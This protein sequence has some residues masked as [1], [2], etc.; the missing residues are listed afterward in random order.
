MP[1][2][3]M[4][5][6]LQNQGYAVGYLSAL[7]VKENK[8][9]RKIDIK[10]VQRHL[11]KIGNL[12]ERV[13]T[14]KEFKGF[15]NSEMKKAIASVTDNY[16]GLEILLT[17]PERC[18]QLASKQIAGATMPEEKVILASILCILGQGKHAPVLAE[19]IRQYKDWD[20]AG[21]T[22][23]WDNSGCASAA[24]MPYHRIG[25]RPRYIR[26][27]HHIGKSKEAGAGRLSF[28]LPCH[29]YGHRSNRQPRSCLRTTGH[30]D[31]TGCTGPFDP[32]VCRST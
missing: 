7:C 24:W 16:K 4:Q 1:V 14:D 18:I 28:P 15:S 26:P 13:L 32:F 5:P 6:C 9:P 22:P 31:D 20:E 29:H 10:K 27:S 11:V 3:R 23:A 8:S 19:A 25:K 21:T 30:A 12:P 17:D 2:I